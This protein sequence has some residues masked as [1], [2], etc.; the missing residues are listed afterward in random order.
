M[1]ILFSLITLAWGAE[2]IIKD[3]DVSFATSLSRPSIRTVT[4]PPIVYFN[5]ADVNFRTGLARPS[6][7]TCSRPP[8]VKIQYADVNFRVG[9][10][11]P[12]IPTI[13]RRPPRVRIDF[14]D[15]NFRTNLIE[16]GSV[17]TECPLEIGGFYFARYP[18][19]D[20]T[21]SLNVILLLKPKEKLHDIS[22]ITYVDSP[23]NEVPGRYEEAVLQ[24]HGVV[25]KSLDQD[26]DG[27]IDELSSKK[28]V[29]IARI[30]INN[31]W[32]NHV[33][34]I[35]KI[36]V[37]DKEYPGPGELTHVS[38]YYAELTRP[39]R[40]R[41]DG[42]S[43][44]NPGGYSFYQFLSD[45]TEFIELPPLG[46][47]FSEYSRIKGWKGRCL[48]IAMTSNL[49][50]EH[51]SLKPV[52]KPTYK[53][54]K[55]D[56]GVLAEINRYFIVTNMKIQSEKKEKFI[57]SDM[58]K[59]IGDTKNILRS[60]K[61]F[62]LLLKEEGSPGGH[63]VSAYKLVEDIDHRKDLLIVYDS[64][65]EGENPYAEIELEKNSFIY[66]FKG[67]YDQPGIFIQEPLK[68]PKVLRIYRKFKHCII[69][70]LYALGKQLIAHASPVR[71]LVIDPE[72]GR[73]TGFV[74]GEEFVNEIEGAEVVKV[75][76]GEA[77]T[78]F[79]FYVPLGPKYTVKFFGKGEGKMFASVLS[80][81]SEDRAKDVSFEEVEV[82]EGM[83]AV[84]EEVDVVGG[85]PP[86]LKIDEDGDGQVDSVMKPTSVEEVEVLVG[87][88]NGDGRVDFDDF[89]SFVAHFGTSSGEEG[90][91]EEFDLTGD[92]K[93]DF[94][95]FFAFVSNFGRT[96]PAKT[97][98]KE[99]RPVVYAKVEEKA[100]DVEVELSSQGFGFGVE[101][102]YDPEGYEF[103]GAE[104][105]GE[106]PVLAK[107]E[108]GRLYF[109]CVSDGARLRFRLRDGLGGRLRVVRAVVYD[110]VRTMSA[111]V[112]GEEIIPKFAL[113]MCRPNPFN[114]RVL[115][116]YS[117]GEGARVRLGV[118]D[119]LG[120]LV[121]VLVD[122]YQEVGR[123]RVVWDGR[124]GDGR[125]VAGGVY[126]VRMEAGSFRAVR[127][128]VLVK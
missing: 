74:E 2:A 105:S 22:I 56:P 18:F 57:Y 124:D 117:V 29:L 121:R 122:G 31:I 15:V 119:A 115:I 11:S 116:E 3:A 86:E 109:G 120:R 50:F 53:M 85:P 20:S 19:L 98:P 67:F 23:E 21:D 54:E 75:P 110:G 89:F 65:L 118:Y 42:Y 82:K 9:L 13:D 125:K 94:D 30:P 6:I 113:G 28:E 102:E 62:V 52:D 34:G 127:K 92:G 5:F 58:E 46:L 68:M 79:V 100:G 106:V 27:D 84:M 101:V 72:T 93:I 114:P 70:S 38:V 112:L 73:R 59:F 14:A 45:F 104:V 8:I 55:T 126:L 81:V 48:G 80:P 10:T 64:N 35:S 24:A 33:I 4:R 76:N 51:P 39:Y 49:Y 91:E 108:V 40:V 83:V 7:P 12:S 47:A 96:S 95:D 61:P 90:F 99:V 71:M 78:A 103:L 60:G 1:V 44:H 107:D 16:P 17:P 63:A 43:F 26:K 25:H 111:E 123:H 97:V 88:F 128:V 41:V 87:D 77:D 66:S 32:E 37:G 36:K 69:S